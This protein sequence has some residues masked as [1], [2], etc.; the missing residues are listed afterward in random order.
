[1]EE[2][3]YNYWEIN[4]I[5][6]E[7]NRRWTVTRTPIDWDEEDVRSRIPTGGCGDDVAEVLDVFETSDNDYSW[8][9]CDE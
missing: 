8:D 6:C 7:S 5:S 3:K 9:F 1:M 2:I 4:Y